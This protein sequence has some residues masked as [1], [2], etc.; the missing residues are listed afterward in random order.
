MQGTEYKFLF[1]ELLVLYSPFKKLVFVPVASAETDAHQ[2][3]M[4]TALQRS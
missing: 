3:L 4:S 1:V 2:E